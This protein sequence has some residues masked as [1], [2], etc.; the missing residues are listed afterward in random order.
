VDDHRHARLR[1]GP[2]RLRD[3]ARGVAHARDQGILKRLRGTPL[4]AWAYLA[5]RIASTFWIVALAV[6]I[7]LALGWLVHDVTPAASGWLP[8]LA[9]LVLGTAC[10]GALGL[11]IASLVPDA[12][13]VPG[14]TL[15]TFMP[16]VFLSG[17]FPLAGVLPEVVTDARRRAPPGTADRRHPGR[18][19]RRGLVAAGARDRRRLDDRGSAR[20]WPVWRFR[21]EP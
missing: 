1:A 15:A 6:A 5:G 14:I 13:A 4:P 18:V 17:V 3:A 12:E 19:P 16:L 20:W 11:A 8:L 2:D 9:T 21:W 7:V 10:L